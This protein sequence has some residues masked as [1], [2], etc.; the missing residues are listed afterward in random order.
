M[1]VRELAYHVIGL[2]TPSL[3]VTFTPI[4]G[5]HGH[6]D[7]LI[8]LRLASKHLKYYPFL[9][10]NNLVNALYQNAL[11]CNLWLYEVKSKFAVEMNFRIL[12]STEYNTVA[13]VHDWHC[14][15]KRKSRLMRL[16]LTS[17]RINL[18]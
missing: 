4:L 17:K 7:F 6:Q 11:K 2:K 1:V 5:L 15:K 14:S 13:M 8:L 3:W 18:T 10:Q 16:P 9:K 12:E